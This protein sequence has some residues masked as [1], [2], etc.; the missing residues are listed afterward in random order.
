[1]AL[2]SSASA[3]RALI[4][5]AHPE[6]R[7]FSSA[8]A[9]VA[10]EQLRS[11]GVHVDLVDLYAEGWDPVLSREQFPAAPDYFKPQAEQRRALASD[12]LGEAVSG[13]LRLAR[14]AELLM[15]SFPLWWFSVPAIMKGWIDRVFVMG[16]AFG[17]EHGIFADGGMRG[18]RA[19]LLVTT[20]GAR[21][22][23]R[24]DAPGGYGDLDG[25]LY[26]INRGMLEFVGYEVLPPII[27]FAPAHLD[28][29]SRTAALARVRA[30]V[31]G[32]M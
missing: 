28:E 30:R 7:S 11:R 16:A 22:D 3:H 19:A 9:A 13:Q 20:G 14:E 24:A 26:H 29:E 18:K 17:G 8:Q 21:D 5:H 25:F 2:P 6:P 1:M 12:A 23:F 15:L 32:L 4:V 10:A 27:T 31:D